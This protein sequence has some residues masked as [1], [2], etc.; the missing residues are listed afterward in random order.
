MEA[1]TAR[2]DQTCTRTQ[3]CDEDVLGVYSSSAVAQ[4]SEAITEVTSLRKFMCTMTGY[5]GG[6]SMSHIVIRRPVPGQCRMS[7]VT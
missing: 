2:N 4:L 6:E 1:I 5:A 7:R 3:G